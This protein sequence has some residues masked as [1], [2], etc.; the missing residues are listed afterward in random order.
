MRHLP[1]KRLVR[2]VKYS[3]DFYSIKGIF[4]C[5]KDIIFKRVFKKLSFG[6]YFEQI[7]IHMS[8]PKSLP[9]LKS[10]LVRFKCFMIKHFT[11]YHNIISL[12]QMFGDLHETVADIFR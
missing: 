9:E 10:V 3:T 12:Q 7:S 8:H 11:S 2:S 5:V 4:K 6:L 1:G